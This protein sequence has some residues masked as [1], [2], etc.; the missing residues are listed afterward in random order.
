MGRIAGSDGARTAAA[1]RQAG[2]RLIHQRGYEAMGLREL[3]AAVGIRPGSLYNH[4][5]SKQDLLLGLI[6]EHMRGL[7]AAAEAALAATPPDPPSRLR[8]FVTHHV[9]YHLGKEAEVYVANFEL[10]ALDPPGRA[11]IVALR[12]RYEALLVALLE[13]G[14][15]AGHFAL[16][17]IRVAAYAILAM[18]TG[19]CTWYRPDGRLTPAELAA[20]HAEMVL[21]GCG[22]VPASAIPEPSIT[23]LA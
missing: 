20:I 19:A 3:A 16:A 21:R 22:L 9:L 4:I 6:E 13:A 8:A 12:R 10:R 2:L 1:I 5:A 23:I 7:I 17:D 18:L 14:T 15:A 11:R